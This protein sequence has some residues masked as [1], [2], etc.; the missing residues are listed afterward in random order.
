MRSVPAPV[1]ALALAACTGACEFGS[2]SKTS[3]KG[4][5]A[6]ALELEPLSSAEVE[7]L[8]DVVAGLARIT[9][10]QRGVYVARGLSRVEAKRLGTLA[11]ALEAFANADA[12]ERPQEVARWVETNTAMLEGACP[13]AGKSTLHATANVEADQRTQTLWSGCKLAEIG[14]VQQAE[15]GDADMVAVL[16][17]HMAYAHLKAHSTVSEDEKTLLVALAQTPR[18]GSAP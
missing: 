17:A 3:M 6:P 16:I 13:G 12:D 18:P 10:D 8:E 15:L 2:A 9:A 4:Q 5:P 1:V 11:K 7:E 14:L